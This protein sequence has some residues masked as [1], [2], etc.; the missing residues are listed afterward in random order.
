MR[1]IAGLTQP[2]NQPFPISQQGTLPLPCGGC[3]GWAQPPITV[4]SR[5]INR[6]QLPLS[7]VNERNRDVSHD[8]PS[9]D[10][11]AQLPGAQPSRRS[12]NVGCGH[13]ISP[14]LW[15]FST[16]LCHHLF[17]WGFILARHPDLRRERQGPPGYRNATYRALACGCRWAWP[18]PEPGAGPI[19]NLDLAATGGGTFDIY[20]AA[21]G[22]TDMVVDFM[23]YLSAG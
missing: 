9:D 16:C 7:E 6:D 10:Y 20:N 11:H 12:W 5:L 22:S 14:S 1:W 23:G 17:R 3:S 21:N 15:N 8:D 18:A 13:L 4:V 19:D 2:I